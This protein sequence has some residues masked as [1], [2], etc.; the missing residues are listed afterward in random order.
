MRISD[1][2]SDVCLSDL[3]GRTLRDAL[4][5]HAD[6]FDSSP[7][8]RHIRTFAHARGAGEWAT[9]GGVLLRAILG[10]PYSVVLPQLVG[11]DMS[12]NL[13]LSRSEE[14]RVGT[15]CVSRCR[16]RWLPYTPKKK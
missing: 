7:E 12:L 13:L 1:W 11:G 2:S 14:R 8:L 9:L 16:S 3:A 6:L 5:E 15:E 10:T 4:T